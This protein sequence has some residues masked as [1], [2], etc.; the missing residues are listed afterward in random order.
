MFTHRAADSTRRTGWRGITLATAAL[1]GGVAWSGEALAQGPSAEIP[2]QSMLQMAIAGGVTM[3]PI[4]VASFLM[5]VIVFERLVSLRRGR[6]LYRDCLEGSRLQDQAVGAG[7]AFASLD[8]S[9]I[10]S[11]PRV[12]L[13]LKRFGAVALEHGNYHVVVP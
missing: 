11:N 4:G 9:A 10:G 3:I 6:V 13:P 8:Q 12:D 5:L 2:T 7:H 1:V